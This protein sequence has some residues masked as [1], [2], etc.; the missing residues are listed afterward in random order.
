MGVWFFLTVVV[1]GNMI[2]KAYKWQ[3]QARAVKLSD[4]KIAGLERDIR[5]LREKV[6]ALDEAVFLGD[7]ELKRQFTKLEQEISLTM[8]K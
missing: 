1:V 6:Q 8:S 2:L 4:D 3:I 5:T 7:F